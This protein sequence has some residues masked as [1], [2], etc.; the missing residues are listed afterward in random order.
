MQS[1]VQEYLSRAVAVYVTDGVEMEHVMRQDEP[2]AE[3][4]YYFYDRLDEFE[5]FDGNFSSFVQ[6]ILNEHPK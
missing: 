5:S 3:L 2:G 4:A 6:M 1:M